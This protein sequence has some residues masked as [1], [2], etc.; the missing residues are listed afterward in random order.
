MTTTSFLF[1]GS[2]TNTAVSG[3][4]TWT[5]PTLITANDGSNATV[6][7]FKSNKTA[8][9][10]SSSH[11]FAVPSGA[12]INGIQVTIRRGQSSTQPIRDF[13]IS[14]IKSTGA[15]PAGDNKADTSTNWTASNGSA[16][17]TYGSTSDLW[18]QTWTDTE[19]NASGFGVS[20][21]AQAVSAGSSSAAQ[22]DSVS[23]AVTYTVGG[24]AH[25]LT[26]DA[27]S[28]SLAG[29]AALLKKGYAVAA[30][31]GSFTYTGT[32]VTLRHG[33]A[34]VAGLGAFAF[35]G[36]TPGHAR[37]RRTRR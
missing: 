33:Y 26:A 2:G 34:V 27:G 9:L 21:R 14:L 37:R 7:L 12:T 6:S 31:T 1:A 23:I 5:G 24:G 4:S 10:Q 22:V 11:G 35:N 17:I 8:R 15:T 20:I 36:L 28:F 3:G 32:S 29:T 19:I 30:A 16:D 18:G 13:E 25:T